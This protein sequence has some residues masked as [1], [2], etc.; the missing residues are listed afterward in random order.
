[1]GATLD[2]VGK[3]AVA[4]HAGRKKVT[5]V[6]RSES[7][8]T[9]RD[10]EVMIQKQRSTDQWEIDWQKELMKAVFLLVDLCSTVFVFFLFSE[11]SS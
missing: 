5:C 3:G 11:H 1:M 2:S 9:P 6:W 8:P 7:L 10:L 4:K